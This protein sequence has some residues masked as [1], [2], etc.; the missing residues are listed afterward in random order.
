[1]EPYV[2]DAVANDEALEKVV[3]ADFDPFGAYESE[4]EPEASD[5]SDFKPAKGK[6]KKAAAAKKKKKKGGGGGG[7]AVGGKRRKESTDAAWEGI[8]G[9]VQFICLFVRVCVCDCKCV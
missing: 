7:A 8:C 1:M 5:D 3:D 4:E 6:A 9:V 2:N